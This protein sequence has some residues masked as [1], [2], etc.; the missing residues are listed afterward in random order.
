MPT[1]IQAQVNPLRVGG[2]I[3]LAPVDHSTLT[4]TSSFAQMFLADA[5]GQAA[6]RP[7]TQPVDNDGAVT[8]Q[9]SLC[10]TSSDPKE[11]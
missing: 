3:L 10:A 6:Q 4:A 9:L 1:E 8:S 5:K 2:T 11:R 7:S